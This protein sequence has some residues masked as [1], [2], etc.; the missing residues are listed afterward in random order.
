VNLNR[1]VHYSNWNIETELTEED[2]LK[3]FDRNSEQIEK[4]L[5]LIEKSREEFDEKLAKSRIGYD[6]ILAKSRIEYNEKLGK[7]QI[8]FEKSRIEFDKRLGE[9]AGTWGKFVAEMVKPKII[10]LF[11]ARNI[12]ISTS[13][14]N[15]EGYI[16]N[17]RHY[18]IDLLLMNSDIA[19]AV[20]IK[21]SLSFEEVKEHLERLEKIQKVQP[22]R[23][24]LIGVTLYGAVA[25]MIIENDA[26]RYAYKKGLFV[27]R[28]NG[29]IVEIV[30]DEKFKPKEWKVEY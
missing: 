30:N 27:L 2:V 5:I 11:K 1:P 7:N 18:E 16:G 21:S 17:E 19:V 20:E 29:R 8:E 13:L 6:E 25:G 24:N 10:D 4:Q 9:L 3:L 15:A 14:Q 12:K 23:I 26:D 28:Q 22:K